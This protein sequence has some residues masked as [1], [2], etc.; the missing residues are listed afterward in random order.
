[1]CTITF[2]V[3]MA[4]CRTQ[5]RDHQGR[6]NSSWQAAQSSSYPSKRGRTPSESRSVVPS[7]VS[8]C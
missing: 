4:S 2:P 7:S 6:W 3:C 5:V 1:M 8:E